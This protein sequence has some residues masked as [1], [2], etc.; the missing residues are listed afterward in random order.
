MALHTEPKFPQFGR[1]F[2]FLTQ[3]NSDC[4]AAQYHIP[5][6]FRF[7]LLYTPLI[8]FVLWAYMS[9][10]DWA[11]IFQSSIS[12][13]S[14]GS[15]LSGYSSMVRWEVGGCSCA[16]L[17]A[18]SPT[19]TTICLFYNFTRLPCT[20]IRVCTNTMQNNPDRLQYNGCKMVFHTFFHSLLA[21]LTF[22]PQVSGLST[23]CNWEKSP[24]LFSVLY[25]STNSPVERTHPLRSSQFIVQC[26]VL[27]SALQ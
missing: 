19:T 20:K 26:P 5:L 9:L 4:S 22:C 24:I 8:V 11:C 23:Q 16:I 7:T 10:D 27:L 18:A 25:L 15:C 1:V 2:C 12:F 3:K 6:C 21:M 13:A 14:L 17:S